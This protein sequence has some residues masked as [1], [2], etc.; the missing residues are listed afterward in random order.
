[1]PEIDFAFLADAAQTVPGQKF[2][3]LGG[4]INRIGGSNFPLRQPHLCLVVGLIVTAS[5][6][7]QE[8]AIRFVLLDPDGGEVTGA[9]GS[10]VARG[11]QDGRDNLVTFSIDLWNVAFPNPGDYSVRILVNGSE[12]KRLPLQI[13]RRAESPDQPGGA[14]DA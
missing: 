13:V 3:V 4:G 8:H 1:M 7:G 14:R 9:T 10:L 11:H 5:E 2:N 6:L 12:R